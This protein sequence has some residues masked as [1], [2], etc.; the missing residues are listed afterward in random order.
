MSHVLGAP[1]LSAEALRATGRT[2]ALPFSLALGDG[3]TLC[4]ETLLRILPGKRVVGCGVWRGRRVLAKLFVAESSARHWQRERD[5]LA[6]LAAARVPT[7]AVLLAT[8]LPD[9]GH[10]LLTAWL[11]DAETLAEAWE[12][13][14]DASPESAAARTVLAEGCAALGRLHAAGLVHDDAHLGNFL[15]QDGTLYVIDGDAVRVLAADDMVGRE[16]NLALMLAQLPPAWDAHWAPLLAA[17]QSALGIAPQI[18]ALVARVTVC[19]QRR[20]DDFLGK[21]GRDCTLFFAQRS[22][23]RF[24]VV[25]RPHVGML[26]GVLTK[27]DAAVEAGRRLKDGRTCTV[28]RIDDSESGVLVVK[29]YNL[30][31]VWH[32]F[33]RSWRPS[34]A[35]HSWREGHRL[36]FYGIATPEPLA[37]VEERFGPLRR[38]AFLVNAFCPG[39]DLLEILSADAEP[40]AEI[41]AALLDLFCT[42][43]AL[44][45]SHGDLK[46][47]NLLWHDGQVVLIDLDAM[48]QHRS[49]HAHV[50]AWQRD[51]ARFLRN[52]PAGSPLVRWL[53]AR[54]PPP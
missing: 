7:P 2:P 34:R 47:T 39:R 22:W 1:L 15:R 24:S 36:R 50:Q 33:G 8:A 48:T 35:W 41:G 37:L 13:C 31:N 6:A 12:S 53:D 32:A 26:Q 25:A 27:L 42:L 38:R 46:A 4:I 28:A 54:L 49:P 5:G 17:Y 21:I 23:R 19:R 20:W 14:G 43:H 44:H 18:A 52:W 11:D 45:I 51:R 29:R 40:P 16:S 30:K 9:G 3:E 10:L